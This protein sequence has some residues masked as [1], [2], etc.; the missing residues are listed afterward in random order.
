MNSMLAKEV[1]I[2]GAGLAG[3]EA[4]WQLAKRGVQVILKEMRPS[5]MTPAH[6]TDLFAELVCSNSLRAESLDNAVGLL[7][8]EMRQLDSL[9]IYCAEQTKLPA[10]GALAVDRQ[11]FSELVSEKILQNAHIKVEIGEVEKIPNFRPLIIATGPLTS[12]KFSQ[13]IVELIGK[14]YLYFHDAAAPIIT[15]D[16]IDMEKVYFA[17][18]YDKGDPDYLNCPMNETEYNLFYEQLISAEVCKPKEF[19]KEIYFEGCMP[20]EVM[21]NRGRKTLVFGPL[22]PVGLINPYTNEQPYAVVQLRKDNIEGTLYNLVGFQTSL[23][24]DEQ[25]KIIRMIPGL[26]NAEIVRYGVIHKNTY[27]NSPELLKPTY[28]L[29]ANPDIFFAGQITGVEGYVESAASGLVAGLNAYQ[30]LEDKEPIIF[31][32]TTAIGALSNYITRPG[33]KNFQPMNITFGLFS[34]LDQK[35]KDKKLK[36]SILSKRALADLEDIIKSNKDSL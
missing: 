25:K 10:G 29:I 13:A 9:I 11:K 8:E 18:R 31:P 16:S 17:S 26:E 1:M 34:N 36:R 33:T 35:I 2:I 12:E 5:T 4:A 30:L 7:K 32:T 27:I 24:W 15:K 23:K 22:K 6:S 3:V 28:Q 21:A 20:V 19:E 14:D